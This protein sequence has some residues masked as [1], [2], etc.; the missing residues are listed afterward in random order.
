MA[1]DP[2]SLVITGIETPKYLAASLS[3]ICLF[4]ADDDLRVLIIRLSR[5]YLA[6]NRQQKE[7]Q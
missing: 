7:K 1:P 5:Y 3:F 6:V 2:T 4:A